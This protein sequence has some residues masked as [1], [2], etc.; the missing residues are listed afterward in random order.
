MEFGLAIQEDASL[1]Y[2]K[3][4]YE[5]EIRIKVYQL[6]TIFFEKYPENSSRVEIEKLLID[7]YISSKITKKL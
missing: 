2:A 5:L 6:F 7:S 1:N 3:L 4:S